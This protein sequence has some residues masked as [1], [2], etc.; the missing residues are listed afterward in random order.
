MSVNPS[1]LLPRE[2]QIKSRKGEVMNVWKLL[3][4]NM[5]YDQWIS[6]KLDLSSPQD[7]QIKISFR[8]S[9]MTWRLH[10]IVLPSITLIFG[11]WTDVEEFCFIQETYLVDAT[12]IPCIGGNNGLNILHELFINFIWNTL[13]FKRITLQKS[14]LLFFKTQSAKKI[15]QKW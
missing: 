12:V 5:S 2:R 9:L 4:R 13:I 10:L 6:S 14:Q 15:L 7:P 3:E 8:P 1:R 11:M